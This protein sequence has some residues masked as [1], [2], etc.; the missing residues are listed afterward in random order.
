MKYLLLFTFLAG[1]SAAYAQT[2]DT[3]TVSSETKQQ[4]LVTRLSEELKL[5]EEQQVAVR[6][7]IRERSEKIHQAKNSNGNVPQIAAINGQA[8]QAL[9]EVL[10]A[11]KYNLFIQLRKEL[12]EQRKAY[13]AQKQQEHDATD[14]ELNF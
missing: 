4:F 2:A 10:T 13:Y 3:T 1:A 5:T 8:K 14:E 7:I 6:E 12:K 11:E 9:K